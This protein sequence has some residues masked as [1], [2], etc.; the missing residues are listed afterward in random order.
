MKEMELTH[1]KVTQVD[2]DVPDMML[3]VGDLKWHAIQ[4]KSGCW[5][6][7][8]TLVLHR[9]IMDAPAG[10]VV[11]HIDRDGLNNLRENMR[12]TTTMGNAAN[13]AVAKSSKYKGVTK[14]KR[15]K[16]HMWR[17]YFTS[18]EGK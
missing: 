4:A 8:T 14:V 3:R 6:A 10:K 1:G 16:G 18:Q 9:I 12:I 17:A 11:D 2:D 15:K 7:T 5:H 13:R